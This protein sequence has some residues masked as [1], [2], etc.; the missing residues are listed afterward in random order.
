MW[1]TDGS[2]KVPP[3]Y[4]AVPTGACTTGTSRKVNNAGVAQSYLCINSAWVLESGGGSGGAP[5]QGLEENFLV[6]PRISTAV[7]SANYFAIGPNEENECRFWFDPTNGCTISSITG[8]RDGGFNLNIPNGQ[9]GNILGAG[10]PLRTTTSTG[11]TTLFLGAREYHPYIFPAGS[12][13]IASSACA[14][15]EI[16]L[17]SGGPESIIVTCPTSINSHF[18]FNSPL[19]QSIAPNQPMTIT[20]H[21]KSDIALT[22]TTMVWDIAAQCRGSGDVY[23]SLWAAA[24]T[25]TVSFVSFPVSQ[26]QHFKFTTAAFLPN[27]PCA[28]G[29]M[30]YVRAVQGSGTTADTSHVQLISA[31]AEVLHDSWSDQ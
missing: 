24:P 11:Q 23:N 12:W 15:S 4:S 9:V 26:N 29:D 2:S 18:H 28:K 27:G 22:S 3:M 14:R 8:G 31:V 10:A 21:A 25:I 6:N 16:A 20:I 5:A 13:Y 17:A 19:R 30:L 7:D 1:N